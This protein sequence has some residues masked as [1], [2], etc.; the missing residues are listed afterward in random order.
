MTFLIYL[1]QGYLPA[2]R[3]CSTAW[4][5]QGDFSVVIY[6]FSISVSFSYW[7]LWVQSMKPMNSVQAQ[8]L[9]MFVL[10]CSGKHRHPTPPSLLKN[11]CQFFIFPSVILS[12]VQF[13][14][15]CQA[16]RQSRESRQT[17][18]RADG[19]FQTRGIW[20]GCQRMHAQILLIC[21]PR[22]LS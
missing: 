8:F 15:V 13:D 6:I 9:N 10:H 19:R 1:V 7:P 17:L 20:L 4:G 5:S 16:G 2:F 18:Q 12:I 22:G 14:C 21:P 3:G 11:L